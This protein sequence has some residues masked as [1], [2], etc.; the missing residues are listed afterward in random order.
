MTGM[1]QSTTSYFASID[2]GSGEVVHFLTPSSNLPSAQTADAI[3]GYDSQFFFSALTSRYLGPW[4]IFYADQTSNHVFWQKQLENYNKI[5]SITNFVPFRK[6]LLVV[7]VV[8]QGVA[9]VFMLRQN[10]GSLYRAQECSNM[11][12]ISKISV[13]TYD[14]EMF[15]LGT[16]TSS[17]NVLVKQRLR[18]TSS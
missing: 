8:R 9:A 17:R 3:Y 15:L 10:D 5:P 2:V 13:D 12:S 6:D 14:E 18:T 11:T 1:V 16:T 4:I 7:G